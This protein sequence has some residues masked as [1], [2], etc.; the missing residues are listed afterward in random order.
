MAVG[1]GGECVALE[2]AKRD[3][4]KSPKKESKVK[5]RKMSKSDTEVPKHVMCNA[6]Y[7]KCCRCIC[8]KHLP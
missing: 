8:M 7:T 1:V 4:N 5:R 6:Y 2:I 3:V